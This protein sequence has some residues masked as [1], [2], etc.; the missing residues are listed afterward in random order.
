VKSLRKSLFA[1]A[2]TLVSSIGVVTVVNAAESDG[3]VDLGYGA[4]GIASFAGNYRK[5]LALSDGKM[6]MF[7]DVDDNSDYN[8][9]KVEVKRFTTA[10]ALDTSFGL[11]GTMTIQ[12]SG[13]TYVQYEYSFADSSGGFYMTYTSNDPN[14]GPMSY[15]AGKMIKVTSAG[16]QDLNFGTSGVSLIPA[17]AGAQSIGG[18]W[19]DATSG[20]I[21]LAEY[22]N[23][24]A[25]ARL[26]S[27]GTPDSSFGTGGIKSWPYSGSCG[28]FWRAGQNSIWVDPSETYA[29]VSSVFAGPSS[30]RVVAMAKFNLS[31]GQ[32]DTTFGG[33]VVNS[34]GSR[35]PDGTPDGYVEYT[36]NG[37]TSL[38]GKFTFLTDGSLLALVSDNS[39]TLNLV[40]ITNA[41]ALDT[42]FNGTGISANLWSAVGAFGLPMST[43]VLPSG[44]IYVV[45]KPDGSSVL[46]KIVKL[47]SGGLIDTSF[48]S[49][50]IAST[51]NCQSLSYL[52]ANRLSDGSIIVNSVQGTGYPAVYNTYLVKHHHHDD[53][54]HHHQQQ[55]QRT[56][57]PTITQQPQTQP[58]YDHK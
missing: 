34:S 45:G 11:N 15:D 28:A 57:T 21:Y 18:H 56:T 53:H 30:Q 19:I 24:A 52:G 16:V 49:G 43:I 27:D 32:C 1:A 14:A 41:G 55:Q 17:P 26:N 3:T 36:V 58:T 5:A 44:D 37:A 9:D 8:P 4:S 29:Y 25:I 54:H 40:K 22:G 48:G 7:A 39:S 42:S 31:S 38:E 46:A 2:V 10:G 6:V 35:T 12:P 13:H 20:K 50:G 47:T 23:V 51:P 33:D